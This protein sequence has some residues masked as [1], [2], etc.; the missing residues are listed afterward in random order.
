MHPM[1]PGVPWP[2]LIATSKWVRPPSFFPTVL[3]HESNVPCL[4]PTHFS[5][6]PSSPFRRSDLV[7]ILTPSPSVDK[8]H[9]PGETHTPSGHF[10][11]AIFPPHSHSH[12]ARRPFS[13]HQSTYFT[14]LGI[15]HHI[16][17]NNPQSFGSRRCSP[18]NRSHH[19]SQGIFPCLLQ[20]CDARTHQRKSQTKR[21]AP[22]CASSRDSQIKRDTFTSTAAFLKPPSSTVPNP[23]SD[24]PTDR[25]LQPSRPR[26]SKPFIL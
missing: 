17:N 8:Q 20:A 7:L 15:I 14:R 13:Q 1:H 3:H 4:T 23:S 24:R 6:P 25:F 10:L 22:R 19:P 26:T 11:P 2:L 21:V 18:L 9:D 5:S 12:S 16:I